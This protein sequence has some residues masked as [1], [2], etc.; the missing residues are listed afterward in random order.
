MEKDSQILR[1]IPSVEKLLQMPSL[2]ALKQQA[3]HDSVKLHVTDR[4]KELRGRL[5]RNEREAIDW[6]NSETFADELCAA[7]ITDTERALTSSIR[8]VFNL[9]GTVIHTNLGRAGLPAAAIVAMHNAAVRPLNLE[10][11][12]QTGKRGDRDS[13]LQ[14]I[15]NTLTGAEAATV[16]NNNA[17]AVLLIANTLAEGRDV[18]ISRGELVEIGG[19]FRI[20]D[21]MRSAH[22]RLKEVGTTNRTHLSDYADA[23]DADTGLLMK[24]HT[25]NYEIRGFTS[26]VS[27]TELAALAQER[28]IPFASDLGSG[29]LVDL[30]QFGLPREL[31]VRE[32]LAAGA[33]LVCFSGDKLLGGPQAGI[34]AGRKELIERIK[35]N[36]FKRALRVDKVTLAALEASLNLYQD[37]TSLPRKLPILMDLT[38]PLEEIDALATQLL[39]LLSDVLKGKATV[40]VEDCQ[41]QIGSGA[42]P[43]DVL[44]SRALVITPIAQKGK[45]EEALHQLAQTFRQ[46][47]EPVIGRL[48]AGSLVFDLRCLREVDEFIAQLSNNNQ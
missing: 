12:L 28:N 8:T 10:Y 6:V 20:P 21:V 16:V 13:H 41:S 14:Q 15:I 46:L 17:A 30:S 34:I 36:P 47:D 44:P 9:T 5:K 11:D 27:E 3:G 40:Q 43:L 48:Q 25:S 23:I 37:P 24:I 39:P 22:C 2:Q 45:S 31:T 1:R 33:E 19:A 4:L 32:A 18:L 38:R 35:R 42:L 29:A 7:I 26:A